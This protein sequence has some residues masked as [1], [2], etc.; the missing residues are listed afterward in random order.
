LDFSTPINLNK[1]GGAYANSSEVAVNKFLN[2]KAPVQL[3]T[4]YKLIT[5]KRI[6]KLTSIFI[7]YLL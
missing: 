6:Q 4:T 5:T 7:W 3:F 1:V 2:L